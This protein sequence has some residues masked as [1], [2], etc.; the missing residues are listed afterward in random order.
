[1]ISFTDI[2]KSS[3]HNRNNNKHKAVSGWI[4]NLLKKSDHYKDLST[5]DLEEEINT[6]VSTGML[7]KNDNNTLFMWTLANT[8]KKDHEPNKLSDHFI[9][10]ESSGNKSQRTADL[11]ISTPV[12]K[13]QSASLKDNLSVLADKLDTLQNFFLAEISDVKVE[14]KNK[15]LQKTIKENSIDSDRKIE[16]LEKQTNFLINWSIFY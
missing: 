16:L 1:M 8:S 9:N 4:F 10:A 15:S 13:D 2:T 5:I 11:E 3:Q 6:L 12:E 14:I 7:H